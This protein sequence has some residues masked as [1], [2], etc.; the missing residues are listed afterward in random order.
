MLSVA[1]VSPI[2]GRILDRVGSK[3]IVLASNAVLALGMIGMALSP[4][5]EAVFYLASILIGAGLAGLMG[6]ALSYIL[7][8]EARSEERSVSQGIITLFISIGQLM[9]GAAVGATAASSSSELMGYRNAFLGIAVFTMLLTVASFLL[10][11]RSAE[12]IV[13]HGADG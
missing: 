8:H 12:R 13:V 9:A 3:A 5:S 11:K 1:F 4:E 7:I 2:A 6:S 10:K